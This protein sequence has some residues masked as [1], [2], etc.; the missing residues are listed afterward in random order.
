MKIHEIQAQELLEKFDIAVHKS[1]LVCDEDELAHVLESLPASERFILKA[2]IHAGGRA[3]G[4][5]TNGLSSGIQIV[6]S[7]KEVEKMCRQMLHQCLVTPQTGKKGKCV[8]GVSIAPVKSFDKEYYLAIF[9][10]REKQ[11]PIIMASKKGGS[12]VEAEVQKDLKSVFK[13]KV[14]P[15]FGLQAFQIRQVAEFLGF[16]TPEIFPKFERFLRRLYEFFSEKDLLLVEIN[17]LICDAEEGLIAL[18]AKM[19]FDDN[20]LFKHRDILALRDCTQEEEY[21]VL[22]RE[23]GGHYIA[24]EGEIGCIVNGAGLAMAT[25]DAIQKLGGTAANFL[26]VGGDAQGKEVGESLRLLERNPQ[27]KGILVNIFGGMMRGDSVAE[28]IVKVFEE[29][30]QKPVVVRLEGL[31]SEKGR[32]ILQAAHLPI[33]LTDSMEEAVNAIIRL[34]AEKK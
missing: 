15:S 6:D 4:C 2:Q 11:A 9:L 31:L 8:Y 23:F 32:G 7:K 18:D 3:K 28:G 27:V 29:G 1:L 30:I 33:V 16:C 13:V 25:V 20:A 21:E 10:D 5:F 12:E 34:V 17:P 26:D 14:T 24:L 19:E 22:A